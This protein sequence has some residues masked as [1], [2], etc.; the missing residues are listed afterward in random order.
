MPPAIFAWVLPLFAFRLPPAI[1]L[2]F[3]W[4]SKDFLRW[5]FHFIFYRFFLRFHS[6]PD[7]HISPLSIFSFFILFSMSFAISFIRHW[8]SFSPLCFPQLHFSFRVHFYSLRHYFRFS[9]LISSVRHFQLLIIFFLQL[10]ACLPPLQRSCHARR[11]FLPLFAFIIF[12][13]FRHAAFLLFADYFRFVSFSFFICFA[14][15]FLFR[16]PLLRFE[17]TFHSS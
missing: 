7:F 3:H 6:S 1:R 9:T 17:I 10:F 8:F 11:F 4:F 15:F 2:T 16:P 5:Y 13:F 12:I 14:V